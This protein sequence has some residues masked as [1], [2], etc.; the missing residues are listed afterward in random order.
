MQITS[1]AARGGEWASPGL[2]SSILCG[3]EADYDLETEW[4]QSD[5]ENEAHV[6]GTV[7]GR[8][9]QVDSTI[10]GHPSCRSVN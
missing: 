8:H 1:G 9:T 5:E 10:S 2:I 4:V 7:L 6:N 3:Q